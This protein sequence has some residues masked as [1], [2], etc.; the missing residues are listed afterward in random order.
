MLEAERKDYWETSDERLK[1][2]VE[3]YIEL[4]E[5]NDLIVMNDAVLEHANELA[6]GFGLQPLQGAK[7][8]QDMTAQKI[9]QKEIDAQQAKANE[10]EQVEGQKL[11]KQSKQDEAE[12]DN[13]IWQAL[14][15]ILLIILLGGLY[16]WRSANR[17]LKLTQGKND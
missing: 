5:K 2:I 11:E 7:T 6:K 8:M 1:S 17:P 15:A 3:K 10:A 13:F 9:K 12:P 14:S 4:V 16:Q